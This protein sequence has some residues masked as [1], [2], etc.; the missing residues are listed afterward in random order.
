MFDG[1]L[2]LLLVGIGILFIIPRFPIQFKLMA[3]FIFFGLGTVLIAG[4]DV[5]FE[6]TST[7]GSVTTTEIFYLIGDADPSTFNENSTWVG[8]ILIAIGA[9]TSFGFL[10]GYI[11]GRY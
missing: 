2:F 6:S 9:L 8:W 1:G 11:G 7:V 5:G 3:V 4:Y 10:S